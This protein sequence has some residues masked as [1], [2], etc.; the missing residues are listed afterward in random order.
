MK[1]A[2]LQ[3]RERILS[4]EELLFLLSAKQKPL[5]EERM[6]NAVYELIY[7]VAATKDNDVAGMLLQTCVYRKPYPR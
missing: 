7:G 5:E 1:R 2:S 4:G 6:V 3:I